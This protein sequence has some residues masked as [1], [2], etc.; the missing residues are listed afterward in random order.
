[1]T[2]ADVV[3]FSSLK[4]DFSLCTFRELYRIEYSEATACIGFAFWQSMVNALADHSTAPMYSSGTT[5][6]AGT[7]VKFQGKYRQ[8]TKQTAALP[9]VAT[10]WTDAPRFTGTCAETYDDF[11]CTFYAPYLAHVVI[12]RKASYIITQLG[13]RGIEYGGKSYTAT[14]EKLIKSL[15]QSINRDKSEAW[16]NLC[17]FMSLEESENNECFSDWHGYQESTCGCGCGAPDGKCRNKTRRSGEY[18]FG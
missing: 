10:D 2:P 9:S 13:D 7:V 16:A 14:D 15:Y 17:H 8:A 1:M 6:E 11:F 5:Y 18:L 3:Q 12:Q 4:L